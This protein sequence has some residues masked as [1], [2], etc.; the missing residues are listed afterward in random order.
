MKTD[1]LNFLHQ[2]A[3]TQEQTVTV[4]RKKQTILVKPEKEAMASITA[5]EEAALAKMQQVLKWRE[6]I[7]TSARLQNIPG[8]TIEQLCEHFFPHNADVQKLLDAVKQRTQQIQLT[9]YTNWRMSRMSMIHISQI[10]ELLETRGQGKAT[11]HMPSNTD[12]SHSGFV[13]RVA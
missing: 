4:L 3:E 8:E 12:G 5:E 9:A 1:I 7:L 6:E 10:L 2:I 13:D 11:Y